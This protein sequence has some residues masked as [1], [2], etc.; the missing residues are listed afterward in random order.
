VTARRGVRPAL[1]VCMGMCL[2]GGLP[3]ATSLQAQDIEAVAGMRGLTLPPAYYELVARDPTA[4][5]L[6]NGLFASTSGVAARAVAVEGTKRMAVVPALFADS[7]EPYVS[8]DALRQALFDGPALRGTLTEAYLEMSRG[9]L[10]VTGEVT[11]WVRTS[12]TREEVVGTTMGL[13]GDARVGDY[14][15]EALSLVDPNLDF[16]LYDNDGPDGQPNSGDDDGIVDA[17]AFEFLEIAASCGGPGIWP[18]LWGISPQ[19]GGEPFATDDLGPDQ[20]PITIDAYIVQSAVDCAGVGIQ[21]ASV[22]AHEFGHVLG[23][24]DYYHPTAEGGADGRRWVLGC[25]ELM[26]AGSWGCGPHT[27]ERDP[28]GPSHLSARSKNRVGWLQYVDVGAV[29]D[30]EVILAPVQKSGEA[31]RVSLDDEGKEFLLLEYR[32]RAGFDAQLPAEGVMIYHQDFDGLLRPG[33]DSG[34]PYFLTVVEQDD[35]RGLLRNTFEGGN[36]GEAGDAWGVDGID[37]KLNALTTPATTTND[38]TASAVAIHS[39]TVDGGVARIRLSTA[40]T[41][42]LVAPAE[43]L[44]VGLVTEFERRIRVAGGYMPFSLQASVPEGVSAR[45]EQDDVVLSGAVADPGPFELALRV[46]DSRGA[47]SSRLLVP[48]TAGAWLVGEDRLLQ[49]FLETGATPLAAAELTYLDYVG[50]GNG[51]Y[52]VGDLRAWLQRTP[53]P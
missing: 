34:L 11:P 26:A 13:G 41:P 2:G 19:N 6:P 1:A 38:G 31:L 23:L 45:A 21:D 27:A 32:S 51:V 3:A 9:Q 15:I 35:N 39:L 29:R 16:G 5:T 42:E 12:L 48:L 52:D 46:T 44:S 49:P 7:P 17:I 36:R 25:W 33:P 24:P 47:S 22:I 8:S 43:P 18:H 28:F 53:S 40:R 37:R 10:R 4:F 14:L 30:H 50:N 20:D